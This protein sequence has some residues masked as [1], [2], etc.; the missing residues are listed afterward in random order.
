MLTSFYSK[1]SAR[2]HLYTAP[3]NSAATAAPNSRLK[4]PFPDSSDNCIS[5]SA[6]QVELREYVHLSLPKT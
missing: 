4:Q 6:L 5:V 3:G 1:S 2:H